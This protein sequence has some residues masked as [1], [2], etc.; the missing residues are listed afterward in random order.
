MV[1]VDADNVERSNISR[2]VGATLADIG[3]PK[4]DVAGRYAR[5]LDVGVRTSAIALN[6]LD[7]ASR[8]YD[9]D[10]VFSCV[11][12]HVPRAVLNRFSY[13]A[14][15]P[16]VDVGTVFRVDP[17]GAVTGDGG[18]VVLVGPGRPCMACW[19]LLDPE[20]LRIEQL[21]D[22]DRERGRA[23]GYV[24]GAEVSQPSVISFNTTVG[25]AAVTEFLRMVTAFAGAAEAPDRLSFSFSA[26][27]VRR[28]T[29]PAGQSCNI[30]SDVGV[31][32]ARNAA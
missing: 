8:L 2:I 7:E 28:A 18:R 29:L 4:V 12:R 21:S 19:G 10:V 23:E 1:L 20:R 16:V 22:E 24:I 32:G 26:G 31:T 15:V 6:R 25:G 14:C 5:G 27:T 17:H 30:C 9:C 11:D 13:E 3:R